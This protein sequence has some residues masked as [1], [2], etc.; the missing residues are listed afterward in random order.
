M[1][2]TKETIKNLWRDKKVRT[3]IIIVASFLLIAIILLAVVIA[4]KN[5]DNSDYESGGPGF[6][7]EDNSVLYNAGFAG[8]AVE[9]ITHYLGDYFEKNYPEIINAILDD[10]TYTVAKKNNYEEYVAT[11]HTLDKDYQPAGDFRLVIHAYSYKNLDY[12]LE[13]I[14]SSAE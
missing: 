14:E 10:K 5:S 3:L 11:L 13:K 6:Y 7:F 12:A 9:E 2:D 1:N 4:R 8:P